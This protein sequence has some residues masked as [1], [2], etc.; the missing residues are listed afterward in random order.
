MLARKDIAQ[1]RVEM[2]KTVSAASLPWSFFQVFS[3]VIG[4]LLA[5]SEGF[6]AIHAATAILDTLT[7]NPNVLAEMRAWKFH[8]ERILDDFNRLRREA[9]VAKKGG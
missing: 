8:V 7:P 2:L 5:M 3:P 1:L 9:E 6:I 4:E